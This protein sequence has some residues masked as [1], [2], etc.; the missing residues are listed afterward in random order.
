MI[1][2]A[3]H[4]QPTGLSHEASTAHQWFVGRLI[5]DSRVLSDQQLNERMKQR[6]APLSDIVHKLE[7]TEVEREFL[8]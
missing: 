8:L 1:E 2:A 6:F 5:L 3:E 7:E 4:T